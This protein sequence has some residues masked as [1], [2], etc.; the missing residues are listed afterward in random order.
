M[1]SDMAADISHHDLLLY[2]MPYQQGFVHSL[3][4]K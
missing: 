3:P 4:K 1:I 2:N